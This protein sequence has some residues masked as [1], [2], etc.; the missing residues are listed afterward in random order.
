MSLECG[1]VTS[2]LPSFT[3][4]ETVAPYWRTSRALISQLIPDRV[5]MTV[6]E[7]GEGEPV[8][9]QLETGWASTLLA[10]V[11]PEDR[12]NVG[13]MISRALDTMT[14][15]MPIPL[16]VMGMKAGKAFGIDDPQDAMNQAIGAH[17]LA[18]DLHG[19]PN[20]TQ[21]LKHMLGI[22]PWI[23][24]DENTGTVH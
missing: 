10:L 7:A 19:L 12:D 4:I 8:I 24:R 21:V 16:L 6:H 18:M 1:R 15:R 11:P 2:D 14:T 20:P 5:K 22:E 3:P 23:R 9:L 17:Y 13:P